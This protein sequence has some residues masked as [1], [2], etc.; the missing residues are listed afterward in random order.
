MSAAASLFDL[1]GTRVLI[2]GAAGGIGRACAEVF[3]AQGAELCLADLSEASV[4]EALPS[5]VQAQCFACDI[6]DRAQVEALIARIGVPDALVDMA[7]ICPYDDWMAP[8]WDEAFDKVMSVN[9]RGPINLVRAVLPGMSAR[10]RGRIVLTGSIAGR[11][12]GIRAVPHYAASKG[13]LHTLVRMFAARA[14]RSGVLVNGIAPGT[15]DTAMVAGQS[16]DPLAFPLG[17]L[18]RPEEVA[19]V[20][21]FLCAPASGFM[22]GTVIDVNSGI[23]VS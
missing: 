15:T 8:D 7:G 21:A 23:Y 3:A 22:A 13:A 19:G 18:A 4:R 14:T 6:A 2:T 10:G 17:R 16:Y 12:G 9:V 11:M 1:T 5:G 20:A